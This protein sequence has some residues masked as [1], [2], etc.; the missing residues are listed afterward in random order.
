ML[1]RSYVILLFYLVFSAIFFIFLSYFAGF[2]VSFCLKFYYFCRYYFS[3][4]CF[5]WLCFQKKKHNNINELKDNIGFGIISFNP[6]PVG[7][8]S[9]ILISKIIQNL[10]ETVLSFFFS[11]FFM[12]FSYLASFIYFNF[13]VYAFLLRCLVL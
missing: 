10:G 2:F 5:Y 8:R 13:I 12:V 7:R 1:E 6:T 11:L 4:S 3:S 9:L